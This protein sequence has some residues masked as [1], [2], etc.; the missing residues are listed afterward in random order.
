MLRNQILP[1]FGERLQNILEKEHVDFEKLQE[2]RL[3]G[4]KPLMVYEDG[5]E[6]VFQTLV[7]G[8]E[9]RELVDRACG[10]SGYAFEEEI[11]RGYL[12]VA[13]GHRLGLVGSVV[14]QGGKVQTLIYLN[15]IN[16]R[17]AKAVEGCAGGLESYIYE[18][19]HVCHCLIISPPGGGKTTLLRDL[20]RICSNGSEKHPGMGVVVVDERSEIAGTYRGEQG[21][22]LGIRTDVLDGCPKTLG[23]EMVLRSMAPKV[24]AVDEI[25]TSDVEGVKH[26]LRCGCKILATLHGEALSDFCEKTGFISLVEEQLFERYIVLGNGNCP[27]TVTKIY[28]K[29]FEILMEGKSCLSN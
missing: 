25:G 1:L 15:G 8:R 27:G 6:R 22:D 10:Y 18:G 17:I 28:G 9:I 26:A 20:I 29:N 16:L 2:I 7:T 14:E 21:F 13:G 11:A 23:M 5:K 19:D 3:R 12:T 4:G 24:L